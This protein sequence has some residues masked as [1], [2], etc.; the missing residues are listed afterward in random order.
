MPMAHGP[1]WPNDN[2]LML[3]DDFYR[4]QDLIEALEAPLG[5]DCEKRQQ[6]V[7]MP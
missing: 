2:G 1:T 5:G 6:L 7:T 4:P 3:P